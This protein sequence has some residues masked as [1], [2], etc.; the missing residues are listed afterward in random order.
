MYIIS[1]K[2]SN[3]DWEKQNLVTIFK[4]G[5]SY[6]IMKCKGCGIKGKR[7]TVSTVELKESYFKTA[8]NNLNSVQKGLFCN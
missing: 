3:H 1:L 5:K 7:I 4:N 6:D 8:I 2:D